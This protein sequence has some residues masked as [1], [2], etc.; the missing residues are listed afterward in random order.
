[1]IQL[2]H[3]TLQFGHQILFKDATWHIL[4]QQRIGLIGSG[5]STLFRLITGN[6]VPDE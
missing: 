5:K 3:I 1:M 2:S 4:P 6:L